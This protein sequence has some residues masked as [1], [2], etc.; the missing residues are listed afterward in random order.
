MADGTCSVIED[1]TPCART[2]RMRGDMCD[3]HWKRNHRTGSPLTVRKPGRTANAG[4]C[5]ENGCKGPGPYRQGRCGPHYMA[6]RLAVPNRPRCSADCEE[7]S[8]VTVDEF[9]PLCSKHYQRYTRH[10]DPRV[11][12]VAGDDTAVTDV[13][14][15]KVDTSS[16]PAA[17]W[18]YTGE[19]SR[20]GYGVLRPGGRESNRVLAHRY[21][22]TL[23]HGDVADTTEIDHVCHND[24]VERHECAG[25]PSC[26]HRRCCNP[27][28]LR[29]TDHSSNTLAGMGPPALNARKQSCVHGH[30]FSGPGSDVRISAEGHRRCRHCDRARDA[31]RGSRR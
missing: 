5:A 25:G 10:G 9:G 15:S 6:L 3:M 23:F 19:I 12:L 30:P 17:C 1:G 16:G 8:L 7:P 31:R 22:W 13:F 24:A 18:P 11:R 14:A 4:P 2:G 29:A 27:N 28:H 21:Q 26:K 20:W